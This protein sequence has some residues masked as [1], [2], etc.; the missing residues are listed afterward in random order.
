MHRHNHGLRTLSVGANSAA[1]GRHWLAGWC[2][3]ALA[4]CAAYHPAPLDEA[5]LNQALATPAPGRLARQAAHLQQLRIPP[6]TLDFSRPFTGEEL[7]VIAVLVNPELQALRTRERVAQAQVFAAGLLPDPQLAASLDR[8]SSG[9]APDLMSAYNLGMSWDIAGLLTRKANQR[10]A[11]DKALQVHY[12]VAWAE[13]LT[14]NQAR[15]QAARLHYLAVQEAV[16]REAAA[17]ADRLYQITRQNVQRGDATLVDLGLRQVALLDAQDRAL[18]LARAREKARQELNRTLGLPPEMPLPLADRFPLPPQRPL[19][20]ARL[21]TRA[22]GARLDLSALRA[23]YASQEGTLYRAILGQYPRFN[24]GLGR[25]RDTGGVRT[26]GFAVTLDLPLFNR[27]R[28]AIAEA[29][30]TRAQLYAEY[31]ARLHQTR[32]DIAAL[33]ADL[34]EIQRERKILAEQLPSLGLAEETLRRAVAEG[35][36]TL[37]SYEAVRA[38]YLDKRLKLLSLE[39]AAAE[40][41]VALQLAIGEAWP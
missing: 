27:N 38:S 22:E 36:A 28:G 18:T 23:G 41:D 34:A 33:V 5:R 11:R 1:A 17:T 25:A 2:L 4:G 16:A 35:N 31:V 14:A 29:R 30:A 32:S 9:Q 40:Q 13:W 24:L 26:L 10:I 19:D 20:P 7:A 37:L 6:I 21:F 8:P 15:L 39:Q 12:D 3:L